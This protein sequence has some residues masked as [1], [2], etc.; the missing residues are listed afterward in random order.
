MKNFQLLFVRH[1]KLL[2]GLVMAAGLLTLAQGQVLAQDAPSTS[3]F[4]EKVVSCFTPPPGATEKTIVSAM[5]E[6][7]GSLKGSPVVVHKGD[8][9]INDTFAKAAVRAILKCQPYAGLGIQGE[10]T[11]NFVPDPLPV[12][13]ADAQPEPQI[14]TT[15]DGSRLSFNPPPGLCRVDPALGGADEQI[16]RTNPFGTGGADLL[17]VW[18][19]CAALNTI[20]KG[21]RSSPPRQ[22]LSV[23]E[24]Q[25]LP[26]N[27]P[28]ISDTLSGF[29]AAL[30]TRDKD[31]YTPVSQFLNNP[32]QDGSALVNHDQQA[33]YYGLR[34][35]GSDG[36]VNGGGASAY[37]MIG[38][39]PLVAFNM[40]FRGRNYDDALLSESKPMIES[41][42]SLNR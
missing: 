42:H 22:M 28:P 41:L 4:K 8:G 10:V 17:A 35:I 31:R 33:V 19:D 1:G 39:R 24:M 23:V 21:D 20:R 11:V 34:K 9:P 25:R 40:T 12:S 6:Q 29:V 5:L 3:K 38:T 14:L 30:V 16:W 7:D 2:R 13:S 26:T 32:T 27:N 36:T 18:I 15:P 37:T